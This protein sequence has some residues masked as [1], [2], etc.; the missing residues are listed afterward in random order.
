MSADHLDP[1]S[2]AGGRS[3]R[4]PDELIDAFFD[5]DLDDSGKRS[6]FDGLRNDP[7]AAERFARTMFVVESMRRPVETSCELPAPDFTGSVLAEI[8]RRRRWMPARARR[9]VAFGRF[10]A[11]ASLLLILGGAFVVRR[12][13]PDAVMLAERPAPL[14]HVME[15]SRLEATQSFRGMASALEP[16]RGAVATFASTGPRCEAPSDPARC[17]GDVAVAQFVAPTELPAETPWRSRFHRA[18]AT[19]V[20][21]TS[22]RP[23]VHASGAAWIR[24]TVTTTTGPETVR[25][26]LIPGG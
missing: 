14:T 6:L 3:E 21:W 5:G 19:P 2:S 23:P 10:A 25:V 16:I 1:L 24:A 20:S 17:A 8:D 22:A 18:E 7:V 11:A 4:V 9:F 13:N 15:V 12:A 26:I